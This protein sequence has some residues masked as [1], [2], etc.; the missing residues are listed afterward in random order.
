MSTSI[1]V[2][3]YKEAKNLKPLV[4]RI[5]KSLK[6]NYEII[7]VDDNSNDGTIET[8]KELVKAGYPGICVLI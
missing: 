5:A 6:S 1:I 8:C 2:P 3:A 4:E 7:I